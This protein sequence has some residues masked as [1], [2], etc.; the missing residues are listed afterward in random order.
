MDDV[1]NL[2][3]RIQLTIEDAT[4]KVFHNKV[5]SHGLATQ[6]VMDILVKRKRFALIFRFSLAFLDVFPNFFKNDVVTPVAPF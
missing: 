1:S 5:E 3:Q 6:A 2:C 4:L